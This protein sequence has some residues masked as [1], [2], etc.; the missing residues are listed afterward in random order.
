MQTLT[1]EG[2]RI[3]TDIAARHGVSVEAA[4]TLLGAVARG[5]G[6]QAQFNHPELGGMGQWSEGGMIMIGDMF[7]SSLKGRVDAL[8]NELAALLRSQPSAGVG[9]TRFSSQNQSQ[10]DGGGVSLFAPGAGQTGP[11]WPPELGDPASTGAQN[12]MRYGWFPNSRRVAIDEGGEVRIYDSGE[13]RISGFSQQQGGDRSLTFTSQ[14]GV[15][16][17]SELALVSP[18]DD[19]GHSPPSPSPGS[20]NGPALASAPPFETPPPPAAPGASAP[21]RASAPHFAMEDIVKTIER[22][23]ELR[24]KN[25]LTEEE[26][27]TKKADL[28]GRL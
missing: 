9:A 2:L 10:S 1:P 17:L 26:F 24:Q 27:A 5:H 16:R 18:R 3:V 8:C 23:A 19:A 28:L 13:H 22:L 20:S 21:T 6:A 25:I 15:V 7:N 12:D 11:W 14:L 4:L